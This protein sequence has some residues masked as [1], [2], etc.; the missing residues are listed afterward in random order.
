M[1]KDI[2]SLINYEREK[3]NMKQAVLARGICSTSYLSKIENGT[4]QASQE[5]ISL[6]LKRLNID[7]NYFIQSKNKEMELINEIKNTYKKMTIQKNKRYAREKLEYFLQKQTSCYSEDTFFYLILIIIKL[8]LAVNDTNNVIKDI[9]FLDKKIINLSTPQKYFLYKNKGIYFYKVN[10]YEN[11]LRYLLNAKEKSKEFDIPDWEKADLYYCLGLLYGKLGQTLDSLEYSNKSS[12]YFKDEFIY[13]R[14][15]ECYILIGISYKRLKR[16]DE[17]LDIYY[18]SLKIIDELNLNQYKGIIYHN[19]GTVYSYFDIP[20]AI[21][22]YNT[23][24]KYK[25]NKKE[26]L[27][28][29]LA[30][31]HEYIKLEEW[32]IVYK[33]A[34]KGLDILNDDRSLKNTP[35]Y[36]HFLICK[37]LCQHEHFSTSTIKEAIEYFNSVKDYKNCYQYTILLAYSLYRIRKY[38]DSS[39][40]YQQANLYLNKINNNI[41]FFNSIVESINKKVSV[42]FPTYN[43]GKTNS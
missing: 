27:V 20:K 40:A 5:I 38:K 36:Y 3:Q 25:D 33:W 17:A 4:V 23:S 16:Y 28:T 15:L 34:N 42:S 8:K 43:I 11:S 21:K 32:D 14:V 19:I 10:D 24:L 30:M 18:R 9:E 39:I 41:E 31:T 22:Y 13:N 26:Q 12:Q 2:G 35:Y 29:I 6:L 1:F 37:E 7:E